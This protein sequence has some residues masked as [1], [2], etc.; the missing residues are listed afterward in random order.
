MHWLEQQVR[1]ASQKQIITCI[2]IL[3]VVVAGLAYFH[4][5]LMNYFSGPYTM[6]AAELVAVKDPDAIPRYWIKTTPDRLL[7]TGIDHI[8]VS[9]RRGRETGRSVTGHYYV[10]LYGER[11]ML[12]KTEADAKPSG[13]LEGALVAAPQNVVSTVLQRAGRPEL[14]PRVLPVMLE[15]SSFTS[16]GNLGLLIAG[17]LSLLALGFGANALVRHGKPAG[18][19]ALV[20]LAA[21][22]S[23]P[24]VR[25]SHA[26]KADLEGRHAVGLSGY[27]LAGT[28]LLKTGGLTFDARSL[29][30]LVWAYPQVTK[31]KIYY[32]IPAG[33][34]HA[35]VLHF[36]KG[37]VTINGAEGQVQNAMR[38]VLARAPWAFV[39]FDDNIAAAM[40]GRV[41][42][43]HAAVDQR[44]AHFAAI[45]AG[46]PPDPSA[47]PA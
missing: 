46:Q 43:V 5:Y 7:D 42:E 37:Q 33:T 19:P 23:E 21:G 47:Q 36:R 45:A 26:I 34:T 2:G 9:K 6:P 31:K 40:K 27:Q 35:A 28:H 13:Q 12:I 30:D 39:G 1:K 44:K 20:K 38:F 11:M 17:A 18:H 8:T 4:R 24:L 16:D 32:V 15:T 41:A 3:A 10:G 25:V 22:S 14:R 29:G